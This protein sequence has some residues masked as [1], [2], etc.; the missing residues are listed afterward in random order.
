MSSKNPVVKVETNLGTFCIEL[1]PDK[2]PLTVENFLKYVNEG[3]YNGVIFHRVIP[4]FVVQAGGF[5]EKLNYKKPMF[6]PIKSESDN[7][8]KNLRG[9]VAMARTSDP[10]SATSQFFINLSD[11]YR[12]DRDY[13]EGDGYGYTVFGKVIE[14]MSVIEKIARI[15]TISREG[16]ENLPL[17][18]VKIIKIEQIQ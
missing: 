13:E 7:G 12:L 2:A 16:L 1:Y 10:D 15:P 8:L 6:P 4:N 18:P 9:T 17:A 11:N 3:F 14:G 5:D